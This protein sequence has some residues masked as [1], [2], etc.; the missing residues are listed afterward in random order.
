MYYNNQY[1]DGAPGLLGDPMAMQR[2]DFG[3]NQAADFGRGDVQFS[4]GGGNLY[5]SY[6]N[7]DDRVGYTDSLSNSGGYSQLDRSYDSMSYNMGLGAPGLQTQPNDLQDNMNFYR[8]DSHSLP[9]MGMDYNQPRFEERNF[10]FASEGDA[11][12]EVGFEN[13]RDSVK[14]VDRERDRDRCVLVVLMIFV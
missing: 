13:R 8:Q 3:Y 7:F 5:N 14:D 6:D 4:G 10:S 11:L 1:N 9:D 12:H 2:D